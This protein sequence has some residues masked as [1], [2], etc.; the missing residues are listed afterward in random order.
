[1]ANALKWII[2]EAKHLRRKFP[3]RFDNLKNPWA[4][5][6]MAEASAIYARKHKG[7][8]PV[9]KK[10]RKVSGHKRGVRVKTISPGV[11]RYGPVK[12]HKVTGQL[13]AIVNKVGSIPAGTLAAELRRRLKEKEDYLVLRRYHET[14]KRGK[15]K[16][17]KKITETRR[18][19]RKLL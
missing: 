5:G 2:K 18:E 6:Y 4:K 13:K 15:K 10:R 9:G 3:H 8:S 11:T 12:P 16:I 7:R 17:S 19:L 1:M 14:T